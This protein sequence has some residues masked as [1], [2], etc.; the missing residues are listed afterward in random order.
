MDTALKQVL[1]P[2]ISLVVVGA[3]IAY[4]ASDT[5]AQVINNFMADL[6]AQG[7]SMF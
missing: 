2:V 3:F 1:I 6:I 5:F 7:K 4:F